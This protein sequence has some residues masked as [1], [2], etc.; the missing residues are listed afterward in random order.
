MP[1]EHDRVGVFEVGGWKPAPKGEGMSE[2]L[3]PVA[4]LSGVADLRTAE[5]PHEALD[6]I[7]AVRDRGAAPGCNRES[8]CFGAVLLRAAASFCAF[9]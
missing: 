1:P 3:M 9:R 6:P 8:Y 2:I 5:V 4:Y 7:D